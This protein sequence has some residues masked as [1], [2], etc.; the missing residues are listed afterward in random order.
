MVCLFPALLYESRYYGS[1]FIRRNFFILRIYNNADKYNVKNC[2]KFM[3][4][5]NTLAS[6]HWDLHNIKGAGCILYFSLSSIRLRKY[7]LYVANMQL[8]SFAG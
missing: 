1:I 7:A 3:T 6:L 4:L 5:L 8:K 2:S